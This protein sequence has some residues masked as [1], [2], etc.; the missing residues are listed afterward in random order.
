MH[1]QKLSIENLYIETQKPLTSCANKD[2]ILNIIFRAG[3]IS[4]PA[5]KPASLFW[6]I[7]CDSG[8]DSIVWTEE[9][10]VM[11][12]VHC[13]LCIGIIV[14]PLKIK[15]FFVCLRIVRVCREWI[16]YVEQT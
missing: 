3:S 7:R 8:A 1:I 15:G 5:V 13:A 4:R 11:V 10:Y 9:D 12:P 2:M 6:Q 14:K 16:V